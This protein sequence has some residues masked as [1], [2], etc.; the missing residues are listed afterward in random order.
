MPKV[1]VIKGFKQGDEVPLDAVFLYWKEIQE[2]QE[3]KTGTPGRLTE[4]RSS[5]IYNFY[6][7]VIEKK[8]GNEQF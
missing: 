1:K 5:I 7:I 6:E 3:T 4:T 2:G 8:P